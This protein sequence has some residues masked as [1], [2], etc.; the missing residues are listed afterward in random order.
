MI[1]KTYK[2]KLILINI[3]PFFES[4][5]NERKSYCKVVVVDVWIYSEQNKTKRR[6]AYTYILIDFLKKT[7]SRHKYHFLNL[8]QSHYFM[9]F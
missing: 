6:G 7:L 9:C 5:R 2:K 3:I 8:T 4:N 1:I